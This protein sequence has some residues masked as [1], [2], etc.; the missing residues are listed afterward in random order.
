MNLEDLNKIKTVEAPPF[1]FTRIQQK[2]SAKSELI[3]SNKIA[4]LSIVSFSVVVIIS[5]SSLLYSASSKS[6]AQ[7]MAQSMHLTSTN[8][9]Y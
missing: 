4:W 6:A 3:V 2:I 9:L 1:L 5:I 7:M 8:N